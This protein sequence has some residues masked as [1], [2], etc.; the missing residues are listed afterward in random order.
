MPNNDLFYFPDLASASRHISGWEKFRTL[1]VGEA[2]LDRGNFSENFGPDI[3]FH[4]ARTLVAPKGYYIHD[5]PN[6]R[7]IVI[8]TRGHDESVA[9][10]CAYDYTDDS[11]NLVR[12]RFTIDELWATA[13]PLDSETKFRVGD[14][15]VLAGTTPSIETRGHVVRIDVS[16]DGVFYEVDINGRRQQASENSLVKY[17]ADSTDPRDWI[18]NNPSSSRDISASLTYIK[19]TNSLTDTIYSYAASKTI[20]RAYQYKPALKLITNDLD[21]LLIAD[22]VG[23]GKTIESGIIWNE[24][25]QRGDLRNV[26][27]VV[28]SNLRDKWRLEMRRRFDRDLP[29]LT[30]QNFDTFIEDIEQGQDRNIVGIA[31][32]QSLRSYEQLDRLIELSIRFDLLIIDEAHHMRNHGVLTNELGRTLISMAD[33]SILLSAT[34]VNMR[35]KD[36]FNLLN[37]LDEGNFPTEQTYLEQI[38]PNRVLNEVAAKLL[39]SNFPTSEELLSLLKELDEMPYG[40]SVTGQPSFKRLVTIIQNLDR[41]DFASISEAKRLLADLSLLSTIFTR[42]R[43][44]DVPQGRAVRDTRM[45]NVKW[46]PEERTYYEILQKVLHQEALDNGHVVPWILQMPLRQA[47]SCLPAS[48]EKVSN[49]RGLTAE[50][51]EDFDF[52]SYSDAHLL[53]FIEHIPATN[54][55]LTNAINLIHARGILDS[56]YEELKKT[57]KQIRHDI[58]TSIQPMPQVLLF[59]FFKMTL[60]YLQNR[61]EKDGFNVRLMYGPTPQKE[62]T[63]LIQDFR[64]G[65]FDILLVSEVGSE[66]LDFEFCNV[67]INYDLP[68]NPMKIEQRIGRLDRFGQQHDRIFIFNMTITDTI[69]G[70]ILTRLFERIDIFRDT[71]GDLDPIILEDIEHLSSM[72]LDPSRSTEEMELEADRIAVALENQRKT[73]QDLENNR[74][75]LLGLDQASIDGWLDNDAPARGRYIGNRELLNLMEYALPIFGSTITAMPNT[76]PRDQRFLIRGSTKL[77]AELY[78]HSSLKY[79]TT[80]GIQE[81]RQRCENVDRIEVTLSADYA[82]KYDCELL[83]IRH[84]FVKIALTKLNDSL[85]Q[86]KFGSGILPSLSAS[87]P[88]LVLCYLAKA[89]GTKPKLELWPFAINLRNGEFNEEVG[90]ELL[91]SLAERTLQPWQGEYPSTHSVEKAL[92]K[93]ISE[94]RQKYNVE[95][96]SLRIENELVVQRKIQTVRSAAGQKIDSIEQRI[97]NDTDSKIKRMHLVMLDREKESLRRKLDKLAFQ[98]NM[99][100]SLEPV[101]VVLIKQ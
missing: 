7:T 44:V 63:Q 69:E 43:K 93:A 25:E 85:N 65:K 87:D 8:V 1:L 17:D 78:L 76:D 90:D 34:P 42:T 59:S 98:A 71:V 46:T 80:L 12:T 6:D 14:I 92:Q 61:L 97:Q 62:R 57:L 5:I 81:L 66:G 89:T 18:Q 30:K 82:S 9:D 40:P 101:A 50:D 10:E 15:V 95:H 23:L 16:T 48:I 94:M 56:K 55:A 35:S 24:L 13:L 31:S 73:L 49:K 88:H 77:A 96:E 36:L 38:E 70:N 20:Y 47:T 22:E 68:W 45:I 53:D 100:L 86:T 3:R 54:D 58:G 41:S 21:G 51:V 37:M 84:P 26:L 4:N 60:E 33:K 27:I 39:S 64:L 32:M 72:S 19:L 52:D 67:L 28:P 99:A 91:K 75:I 79:G 11:N 2:Q 83:S 74:G 29:I